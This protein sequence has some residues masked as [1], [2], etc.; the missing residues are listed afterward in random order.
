MLAALDVSS[1][2]ADQ[3]E[4]YNRLISAQVAQ[5]ARAI[6]AVFFR[7]SFPEA[8][9]VVDNRP[10]AAGAIATEWLKRQPADGH[11]IMVT[12][13]GAAAAAPAAMVGGT[14]KRVDVCTSCLKAGKVTR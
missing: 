2:R 6:E 9:I 14:R 7:A 10:G 1:A 13:T 12:E 4:R 8:R 11:T 5:T 3:T